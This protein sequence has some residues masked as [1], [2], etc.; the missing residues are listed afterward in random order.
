MQTKL[1]RCINIKMQKQ[2]KPKKKKYA[3]NITM[4]I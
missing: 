2:V 1:L 4:T 3:K